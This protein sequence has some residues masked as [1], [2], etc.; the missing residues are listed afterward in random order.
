MPFMNSE[1]HV[2]AVR[3]GVEASTAC[4]SCCKLH[5]MQYLLKITSQPEKKDELQPDDIKIIFTGLF[6]FFDTSAS[7]KRWLELISVFFGNVANPQK[8][9]RESLHVGKKTANHFH[10]MT[11]WSVAY[12][13]KIEHAETKPGDLGLAVQIDPV[14][15]HV[16]F[17][18]GQVYKFEKLE[19]FSSSIYVY[20]KRSKKGEPDLIEE[21]VETGEL[22]IVQE[23]DQIHFV[24]VFDRFET[25]HN[26]NYYIGKKSLCKRVLGIRLW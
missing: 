1:E 7:R 16:P 14:S 17:F 21:N 12:K 13:A 6:V 3:A 5:W 26:R 11:T 4:R 20:L 15:P 2:G 8:L 23:T 24:F 9:L 22:R 19:G 25:L 18:W 10:A